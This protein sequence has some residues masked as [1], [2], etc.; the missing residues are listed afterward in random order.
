MRSI[1]F[2]NCNVYF[3]DDSNLAEGHLVAEKAYIN[4]VRKRYELSELI[5]YSTRY[6]SPV[7][8]WSMTNA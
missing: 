1:P 2:K 5:I 4:G 3:Y 8:D 7:Y 6:P